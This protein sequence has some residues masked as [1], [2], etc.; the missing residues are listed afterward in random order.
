MLIRSRDGKLEADIVVPKWAVIAC[1]QAYGYRG[2]N[3]IVLSTRS[4][5]KH[6]RNTG[7]GK[8]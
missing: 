6:E 8:T 4:V 7:N 2:P 5:P 1:A 3:P